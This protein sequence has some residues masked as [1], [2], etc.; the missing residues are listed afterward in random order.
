MLVVLIE[1]IIIISVFNLMCFDFFIINFSTAFPGFSDSERPFHF[2]VPFF[3][4]WT[5]IVLLS[6]VLHRGSIDYS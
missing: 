1:S 6:H 3:A 4:P 2:A 5:A